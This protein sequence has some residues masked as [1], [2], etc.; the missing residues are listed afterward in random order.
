MKFSELKVGQQFWF[1]EEDKQL[2]PIPNEKLGEDKVLSLDYDTL[3]E[4]VVNDTDC[5]VVL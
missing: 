4:Y 3:R 2:C 5:E 1:S